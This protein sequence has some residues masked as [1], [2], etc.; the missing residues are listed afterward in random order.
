[1]GN[2][3]LG[4]RPSTSRLSL[5]LREKRGL[6]YGVTSKFLPMPG[7]GPFLI[8]LSTQHRQTKNTIELT[9]E[10]ISAF[11]RTG[12]TENELHAAKQFLTGNFQLSLASNRNIADILLK[13][14]FYHLPD[15]YIETYVSRINAV[16]INDIKSAFKQTLNP[17]QFL[18]VTVGKS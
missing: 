13:I 12:P 9:R 18:Q 6:T 17:S 2:Y 10:I 8:G 5:E 11:I 1:V 16:Q 3:I 7:K 14:D 4:G 15:D